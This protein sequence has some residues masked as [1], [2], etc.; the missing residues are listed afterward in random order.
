MNLSRLL[1]EFYPLSL[2]ADRAISHLVLDSRLVQPGDV[3]FALKGSALDGRQFIEEAIQKGACAILADGMEAGVE[4]KKNV[5]VIFIPALKSHVGKLAATF[6]DHPAKKMRMIGVTG[7]SGKTSCTQFMAAL[8]H[9]LN[10][11]CGVT[12]TLGNGLYGHTTESGLTTPDAIT[13][14][15]TLADFVTQGARF[16]AMEVSSHS[17]DQGRVNGIEFQVGVFTNLSR[18]HLDYHHTMVAYGATKKTVV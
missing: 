16:T 1:A 18:D 10:I 4:L 8:F 6:Y 12:G 15:K 11:V 7:T 9:H 13:L 2:P 17:L 5:P 14:Q 3:F